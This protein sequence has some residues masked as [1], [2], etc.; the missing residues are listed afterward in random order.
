MKPLAFLIPAALGA[1]FAAQA[2][3]HIEAVLNE[4]SSMPGANLTYTERRD[5]DHRLYRSVT[6]LTM[7]D[8]EVYSRFRQAFHQ[9]RELTYLAIMGQNSSNFRFR[10]DSGQSLYSLTYDPEK[11]SFTF[12]KQWV[13][14]DD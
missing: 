9:D 12:F 8:N 13:R 11:G 2:Q 1:A 6:V 14:D 3:E 5:D 10:D 7:A 4:V